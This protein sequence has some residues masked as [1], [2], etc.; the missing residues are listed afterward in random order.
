[1]AATIL[2]TIRLD[3]HIDSNRFIIRGIKKILQNIS[4]RE[5]VNMDTPKNEVNP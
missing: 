4:P 2:T 5:S 3:V 1:M